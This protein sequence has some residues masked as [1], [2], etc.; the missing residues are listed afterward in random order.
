MLSGDDH[1]PGNYGLKDQLMVMNWVKRNIAS[2]RGDPD[3]VMLV[4]HSV[5]AALVGIHMTIDA[6][7]GACGG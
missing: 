4:G 7:K 2:F 3:N 6:T 1:L 5:G